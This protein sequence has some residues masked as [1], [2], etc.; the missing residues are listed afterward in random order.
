MEV[1]YNLFLHG[2][3]VHAWVEKGSTP[4]AEIGFTG[5]TETVLNQ[6][7]KAFMTYMMQ[8]RNSEEKPSPTPIYYLFFSSFLNHCHISTYRNLAVVRPPVST[9]RL[10]LLQTMWTNIFI[11]EETKQKALQLFCKLQR[12]YRGWTLLAQCWRRRRARMTVQHDLYMNPLS[13]DHP[14]VFSLVQNGNNYL[15]TFHD[16]MKIIQN[17]ICNTQHFY[18][19]AQ[20]CRNPY[21]N[22]EFSKSTLYNI[23]Y[24]MLFRSFVIPKVFL[25]FYQCNFDLFV[26]KNEHEYEIREYAV[27]NY[28]TGCS[29]HYLHEEVRDMIA[30][31]N[32]YKVRDRRIRIHRDFPPQ[33]LVNIMMPYYKLFLSYQYSIGLAKRRYRKN[34]LLCKMDMF[35]NYNRY[36]GR[37]YVQRNHKCFG[38]QENPLVTTFNENHIP[39]VADEKTIDFRTSHRIMLDRNYDI[40][41]H[42]MV[43]VDDR[44]RPRTMQTLFREGARS[45]VGDGSDTETHYMDDVPMAEVASSASSSE[46]GDDMEADGDAEAD[47]DAVTISEDSGDRDREEEEEEEEEEEGRVVGG[48]E[49]RHPRPDIPLLVLPPR[50]PSHEVT[51]LSRIPSERSA[52]V[53]P[54][55]LRRH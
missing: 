51:S 11:N 55:A 6:H 43:G 25:C 14:H 41:S 52:F 36:F 50:N 40:Y 38:G 34:Q 16:L 26:F 1:F 2:T 45:I 33:T 15:F 22:C 48:G 32:S 35:Y 28:H 39:F 53:V 24:A 44:T 46:A 37:K 10:P 9:S 19:H 3:D 7:Y 47:E 21:N 27:E 29:L 31:Y 4:P 54:P 12:L 5:M 23:F 17:A 18:S 42:L 30:Y 8:I 20:A 49:T 13:V